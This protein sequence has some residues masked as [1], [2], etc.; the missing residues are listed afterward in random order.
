MIVKYIGLCFDIQILKFYF[1]T[2]QKNSPT[3]MLL[4]LYDFDTPFEISQKTTPT[5]KKTIMMRFN[6]HLTEFFVV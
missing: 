3:E 4:H 2:F 1:G 6:G 5:P